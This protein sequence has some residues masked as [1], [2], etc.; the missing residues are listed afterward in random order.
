MNTKKFLLINAALILCASLAFS[1]K[2]YEYNP[3]TDEYSIKVKTG[4][5]E[6]PSIIH[7]AEGL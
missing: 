2:V 3:N 6:R 4:K 7:F 5:G 1:Q